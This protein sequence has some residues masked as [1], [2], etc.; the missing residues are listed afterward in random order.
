M[1]RTTV[2]GVQQM[3]MH[4]PRMPT[5]ASVPI[6]VLLFAKQTGMCAYAVPLTSN[7]VP[8]KTI[9]VFAISGWRVGPRTNTAS[10]MLTNTI[11]CAR[12][13]DSYMVIVALDTMNAYV[14]IQMRPA[15]PC[16][17]TSF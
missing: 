9:C 3:R 7:R 1:R 10:V 5:N 15:L 8:H 14:R 4:V 16:T 2:V 6:I 13:I 17:W 12:A 11:A